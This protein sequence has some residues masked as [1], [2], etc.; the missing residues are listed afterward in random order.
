MK[1]KST[2]LLISIAWLFFGCSKK[3]ETLAGD[4]DEAQMAAAISRARSETDD[5]L[6]V[7]S[8]DGADTFSVKAPITDKNGTEHFWITDVRFEDG[9]FIGLIGND[10]GIVKNVRFGQEWKIK[11]DEI[12]DWMYTRGEKIHGG[13]TIDPLLHT[14]PV[15]Q[16]DALR[17]KLV[18]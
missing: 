5:F 2:L 17:E 12:S 11:K 13:Y 10:P 4:Y 18:R 14:F 6:K 9:M 8:S 16:A 3:P 1:T 7:L 15:V